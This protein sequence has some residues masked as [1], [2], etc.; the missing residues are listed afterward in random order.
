MNL[1]SHYHPWF[2]DSV[3]EALRAWC[4]SSVEQRVVLAKAEFT[5]RT[6]SDEFMQR[7]AAAC[8]V[9]GVEQTRYR[10]REVSLSTG[11]TLLAGVHFR[12]RAMSFPFVGVFA[13][14]RW[15]SAEE[16]AFAH[17]TLISEFAEF[18]PRATWWWRPVHVA[19]CA[20]P[21]VTVDQ[22]LVM[23]ALEEIRRVP[24]S[25][26]PTG[27]RVR[28]LDMDQQ[29]ADVF[30]VL[31]QGFHQAR[32]DLATVV[33][34]SELESLAE[35][36]KAGG[37]FGCFDGA[38]VVAIVALKPDAR[39]AAPAWLV[40]DSVL[41]REHCGQGLAPR[42]QRA[43]LDR[44]DPSQAALVAGTIAAANLPSLRTALRVGRQIMG[45]WA[46]IAD[47]PLPT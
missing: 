29:I 30:T 40:W 38:Q 18:R 14:S 2:R 41:A 15:L 26:L 7:Y 27:W 37:L 43:V 28:P 25:A 45:S 21:G 31:Y 22:H 34:V 9:A 13:Q 24:A 8:P 42:V 16:T 4:P 46:F 20:G 36:A 10:L 5:Q 35:C 11:A 6:T 23:G 33:P 44:L 19:A 47:V 39:Y 3:A 12:G 32:P 17:R 1:P